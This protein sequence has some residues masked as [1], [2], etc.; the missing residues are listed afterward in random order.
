MHQGENVKEDEGY[1]AVY[2]EQGAQVAA[3]KFLDTI[4]Q[5]PG[6]A[7]ETSDEVPAYTPGRRS[8]AQQFAKVT[9]SDCPQV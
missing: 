7:I 6:L 2:T 9:R 5:L 4:S 1:R 3:A 8:E